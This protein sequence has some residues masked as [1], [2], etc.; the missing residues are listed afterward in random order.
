MARTAAAV[1]VVAALGATAACGGGGDKNGAGT[2]PT[3]ATAGRS[4]DDPKTRDDA[5]GGPLTAAQLEKAALA[6][7]DVKGYKVEK[8]SEA[9]MPAETVPA[10][11]AACQP[12]AD[13]FFFASTP[14]AASRT[15]RT[16]TARSDS[17]T[18]VVSLALLAHEQG[19]AEKVVADLRTASRSCTAYEHAGYQYSDVK[20]LPAPEQGDEA[21][22]YGLRGSI[23][24]T[25]VPMTFTIVRSGS[26][27]VAFYAMNAAEGAKAQ[28]PE[29]VIEAQMEK[30]GE[31]EEPEQASG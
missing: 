19:N 2:K 7:G 8:T 6:A 26:T 15:G 5:D 30:L 4:P 31:L 23:E 16:L 27:L 28:V 18:N 22:A 1:A 20:A 13:M 10:E 11:P 17:D 25:E 12:V 21:V 9:D 24:G 14:R 29:D 3:E